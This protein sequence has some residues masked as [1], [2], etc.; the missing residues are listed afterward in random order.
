MS[1]AS[2]NKVCLIGN[3]GKDPEM[4][5][6]RDGKLIANFSI[7]TSD[8]W[9]NSDGSKGER[10]E[11][12]RVVVFNEGLAKVV[13]SY[14]RKGDKLYLEGKLQTRKW[15]NQA[16]ADQYTTEVVLTNFDGKLVM[17]GSPGGRREP[18]EDRE[19]QPARQSKPAA[20]ANGSAPGAEWDD[21]IPF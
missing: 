21:D 4:R 12:H 9:K 14:V 13:Q 1:S 16:G 15:V 8:S 20:A 17:L 5:N 10:T 18:G 3:L 19:E 7:A 11:W 2:L 6:T